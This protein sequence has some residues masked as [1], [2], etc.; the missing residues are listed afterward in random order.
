[1]TLPKRNKGYG[2]KYE[3]FEH[4]CSWLVGH[5]CRLRDEPEGRREGLVYCLGDVAQRPGDNP[6][7]E[8]ENRAYDP[9]AEHFRK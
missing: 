5:A 4:H 6:G 8:R 7:Y 3:N 9:H 1:M 2:V